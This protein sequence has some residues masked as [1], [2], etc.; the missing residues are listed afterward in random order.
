MYHIHYI[1][2][3]HIYADIL[4]SSVAKYLLISSSLNIR[5]IFTAKNTY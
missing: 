5:F 3:Q 1:N 2:I 4:C